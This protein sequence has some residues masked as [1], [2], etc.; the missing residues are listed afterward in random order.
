VGLLRE[1]GRSLAVSPSAA[2][3]AV[4]VFGAAYALAAPALL[5]AA[6]RVRQDRLLVASLAMFAFANAATA[7]AP[8]FGAL[9]AARVLAAACAGVFTATAATAAGRLAGERGRA[10]GLAAV[11]SGASAATALGVP[12]GTFLG[13]AVGWRA[14]FYGICV[15]TSLVTVAIA[16]ARWPGAVRPRAAALTRPRLFGSVLTL[17]TTLLWATGSFTF[18]TYVAIVLHHTAMVG[19][20]GLA[21]FL[22]LFGLLGVGG[23]VGAGWLTDRRGPLPTLLAALAL[24]AAALAGLGVTAALASGAGAVAASIAAIA[25]YGVGTWAVTP[26]QQQRLL[27]E[28][29]DER[30]LLSLNASALYGGVAVG[31]ALG[32]AILAAAGSV[33]DLCWLAAAIEVAALAS[34]TTAGARRS[35]TATRHAIDR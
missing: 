11:V 7:A 18:F 28:A 25:V 21:G 20:A 5:W 30:F 19:A 6:R 32:G 4:T 15:L 3:H 34:V 2:G 16:A 17:A 35:R 1:M 27:A 23:A 10:S 33:A 22:L 31:S 12:L 24:V 8:T 13:G 14:I 9:L 29:N 26:P